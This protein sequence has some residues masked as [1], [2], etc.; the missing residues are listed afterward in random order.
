MSTRLSWRRGMQ[1]GMR[2]SLIAVTLITLFG[3]SGA[4]SPA[5]AAARIPHN[6]ALLSSVTLNESSID[7]PAL[8]ASAP[9]VIG[10]TLAW[11]G[12]DHH[13]N[14]MKSADG[15][16]Y[17]DKRTLNEISDM[18]PAIVHRSADAD[19]AVAIA[20]TGTDHRLNIIYDAYN[21]SPK[22]LTLDETSDSPPALEIRD[23]FLYIAWR[24]SRHGPHA[25]RP[26]Y[27]DQRHAQRRPESE[28]ERLQQP[29][30]VRAFGGI[31]R[32]TSFC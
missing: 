26:A 5:Q 19:D 21:A 9:R 30:R 32:T 12:T 28:V 7:G 20:W 15:L 31:P 11:T 23:Y 27:R 14:I 2:L 29:H 25:Q 13:L 17:S 4:L 18:R 24:G 22:K 8:Y 6:P 3:A 1:C 10:A 16:H